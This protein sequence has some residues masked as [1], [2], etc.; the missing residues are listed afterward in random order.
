MGCVSCKAAKKRR[1]LV[2]AAAIETVNEVR[3]AAEEDNPPQIVYPVPAS[4]PNPHVE[5]KKSAA[6]AI[7]AP[8]KTEKSPKE[9]SRV[10][11]NRQSTAE[12]DNGRAKVS[13]ARA[14]MVLAPSEYSLEAPQGL[15][16]K[17][18]HLGS[19]RDSLRSG[20]SLSPPIDTAYSLHYCSS[21][22]SDSSGRARAH[23]SENGEEQAEEKRSTSSSTIAEV[24][25]KESED[26]SVVH[27][28]PHSSL[29][30]QA[31][32][33][34]SSNNGVT[35]A[36]KASA[37]NS[38]Q[39]KRSVSHQ[40]SSSNASDFHSYALP[41]ETETKMGPDVGTQGNGGGSEGST[42]RYGSPAVPAPITSVESERALAGAPSMFLRA[43][44]EPCGDF[45]L[46][47]GDDDLPPYEWAP[48]TFPMP[49]P[50]RASD[51][52]D[53]A[54]WEYG[55]NPI[56]EVAAEGTT[57][58]FQDPTVHIAHE[59]V[60]TSEPE[61]AEGT[62][63]TS[64]HLVL[65]TFYP[66]LL[67]AQQPSPRVEVSVSVPEAAE[68]TYNYP[69]SP[70]DAPAP[71]ARSQ[72]RQAYQAICEWGADA[73]YPTVEYAKNE[74]MPRRAV[75]P[76]LVDILVSEEGSYAPPPPMNALYTFYPSPLP[77]PAHYT[78]KAPGGGSGKPIPY[79]NAFPAI[80]TS[81]PHT[82]DDGDRSRGGNI[83]GGGARVGTH[84][85]KPV[86]Y[87]FDSPADDWLPSRHVSSPQR[88]THAAVVDMW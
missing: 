62:D 6:S 15:K 72:P 27:G 65:H 55:E 28:S 31:M 17:H 56:T 1:T 61:T 44:F 51:A 8:A 34:G 46:C 18:L 69:P 42:S 49:R 80:T 38:R 53:T 41:P 60:S 24:W 26:D 14:P 12:T 22:T 63:A 25:S 67:P 35:G 33:A 10:E 54:H 70:E 74:A 71:Q 87:L 77:L 45:G 7:T 43:S 50:L 84:Q 68:E 64:P 83:S 20:N 5:L 75:P 36:G 86:T 82:Y 16:G 88:T 76:S 66:C 19:R 4:N 73:S 81:V 2:E 57:V 23:K 30:L 52:G 21:A 11:G 9:N 47:G 85:Y 32:E 58:C 78:R 79:S 13:S 3:A 48:R 37:T 59:G 40:R 39:E 29:Q